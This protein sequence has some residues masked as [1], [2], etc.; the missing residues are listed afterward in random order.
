MDE[1]AETERVVWAERLKRWQNGLQIHVAK[2]HLAAYK[3]IFGLVTGLTRYK[4]AIFG[5]AVI[6]TLVVTFVAAFHLSGPVGKAFVDPDRFAVV[7]SFLLGI[8]GALIGAAAIAFSLI[9]FALQV[10]VERMPHGLFRRLSSDARLL[11]AFAVAFS[12]AATVAATSLF[13]SATYVSFALAFALTATVCELALF[14]YAYRRALSLINPTQQLTFIIADV[15]RT[16]RRVDLWARRLRPIL[17]KDV[18]IGSVEDRK[19]AARLAFLTMNPD[20]D[21]PAKQAIAYALSYAQRFAEQGD[22]EVVRSAYSTVSVV[23]SLYVQTKGATFF[24]NSFIIENP[25]A[26]DDFLMLTLEELRQ[27]VRIALSR[28]DE[29]QLDAVLKAM[30]ALVSVYAK[31]DYGEYALSKSHALMVAGYLES[32]VTSIIP[33]KMPD[34]LMGGVR[35]LGLAGRTLLH[36]GTPQDAVSAIDKLGL[37]A[38]TGSVSNDYGV[39]TLE[40]MEQLTQ[41]TVELLAGEN[42]DIGFAI[43]RLRSATAS[44]AEMMLETADTSLMSNHSIY[45]GPYYS[46]TSSSS[47][48][49]KLTAL[50]NAVLNAPEDSKDARRIVRNFVEW[51]DG[52]YQPH[53]EI[54]K[55]AI[56]KRSKFSFDILTW[57]F[58]VFELLLALANAPATSDDNASKLRNNA[59]WLLSCVYQ[60][61]LEKD[62]VSFIES[63]RVTEGL[64][65]CLDN[66]LGR[67]S[68][69]LVG[70]VR[71]ML[72][73]WTLRAGSI[74]TGWGILSSGLEGLAASALAEGGDAVVADLKAKLEEELAKPEAPSAEVR[75]RAA[76]D[77]RRHVSHS[78]RQ[79]Y[80]FSPIRRVLWA[81]DQ[82]RRERLLEEL[83]VIL[84]PSANNTASSGGP[85]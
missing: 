12:L 51:S 82:Q 38:L 60:I 53:R 42:H 32:A 40:A 47:L 77:L 62:S 7:T 28:G 17:A 66:A 5:T 23:N 69:D 54:L 33:H 61:P 15:R 68:G 81:A 52:L 74:E 57:I 50:T 39:I 22:Y 46:S 75:I 73:W 9:L 31:I 21:A 4:G 76:R 59:L 44:A 84:S 24:S 67:D 16:F 45:L 34:S 80:E 8:G 1:G 70:K 26:R 35:Q 10:N 3:R 6:A 71:E 20:W 48:R 72:L 36:H 25:L 56:A 65:G 19:D 49:G 78:R 14:I 83:A 58:G 18:P 41:L 27:S 85:I 43:G 55:K 79:E 37:M 64:F 30:G 29:R 2:A 13:P 11:G 63:S